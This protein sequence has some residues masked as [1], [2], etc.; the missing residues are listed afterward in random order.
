MD[1]SGSTTYQYDAKGNTTAYSHQSDG[2]TH[3]LQHEYDTTDRMTSTT[4]PS[5]TRLD[6]QYDILSR[7]SGMTITPAGGTQQPLVSDLIY[8]AFG[9]RAAMTYG[10]GLVESR[11]YDAAGRLSAVDVDDAIN[12]GTPLQALGYG[13]DG[14][15]NILQKQNQ[16]DTS[17]TQDYTYDHR[18]RLTTA[19]GIYGALEYGYDANG[20]RLSKVDNT[21]TTEYH[22]TAG[23]HQL[24]GITPQNAAEEVLHRDANGNRSQYQQSNYEWDVE[25]RLHTYTDTVTNDTTSYSYDYRNLRRQKTTPTDTTQY[26]Y[27]LEGRLIA[28][29][30]SSTGWTEYFFLNLEMIGQLTDTLHFIYNDHL[31]TP[32]MVTDASKTVTWQGDYR[33]FGGV[34]EVVSTANQRIRFPGQQ[35]DSESGLYYN[36]N[37]Y[38]DA[39]TGRYITSDPIGLD[40]GVNTFGY[41]G[42]NPT[43]YFDPDGLVGAYS[44]GD[45]QIFYLSNSIRDRTSAGASGI[46]TGGAVG[47][48]IIGGLVLGGL[49][50]NKYSSVDGAGSTVN[51]SAGCRSC[52]SQYPNH[53]GCFRIPEYNFQSKREA[54]SSFLITNAKLHKPSPIRSGPCL[55]TAGAGTH[56]NVRIGST[57]IGSITSCTCCQN[58]SSGPKLLTRYRVH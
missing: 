27:D 8:T 11:R 57:R 28:E 5:G 10:N 23:S 26:V 50:F 53:L 2:V 4:Y 1:G 30:S 38:Y 20:N 58:G 25:N 34:T 33:P 43:A 16:V 17:R 37:R 31:A 56:W 12:P 14:V 3:T 49:I 46:R 40:G 48:D 52:D 22:Y 19:N 7:I 42:G 51:D 18:D 39:V 15:G 44:G 32:Q 45:I 54:L 35:A 13:F 6:Y 21:D 24:S 9:A 29:Y 41:V 36:W 47:G 55:G